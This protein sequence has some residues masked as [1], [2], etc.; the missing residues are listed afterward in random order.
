MRFPNPTKADV[1]LVGYQASF[2]PKEDENDVERLKTVHIIE[3]N[4]SRVI[5]KG[6][7][8]P[9]SVN[10]YLGN[11]FLIK[12][13]EFIIG[14]KL[15]FN[16]SGNG[17]SFGSEFAFY[18]DFKKMAPRFIPF[19]GL[20]FY[21]FKLFVSFPV[22]LSQNEFVPVNRINVG[23]TVPIYNLNKKKFEVINRN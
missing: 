6:G 21:G 13:N 20:G 12:F 2:D 1:I 22:K 19:V 7:R 15:G 8:H 10:Y 17:L 14:P 4:I 23:I 11:D 18:T 5:D 3:V 9:V 16:L